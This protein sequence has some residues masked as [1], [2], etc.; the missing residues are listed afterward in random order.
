MV[1]RHI[2]NVSVSAD[3]SD[4]E[5]YRYRLTIDHHGKSG[6]ETVCVIMQN[7]SAANAERADRT[8]QFVEKLIFE[9]D[10]TQ[11]ASAN[12][13]IIVNLYALIQT[14]DFVGSEEHI[15][16]HN[17]QYIAD[18]IQAADHVLIGWGKTRPCEQRLRVVNQLL[19]SVEPDRLWQTIR[20]PSRG[21]YADFITRYSAV[22][23]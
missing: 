4:C 6:D 20:H 10:Y 8:I 13:I 16:P 2:D 3:F 15:G 18:S 14:H 7:P 17:D 5:R 21:R 23:S 11:F 1:Y 9:K 19:Q 12:R 22:L